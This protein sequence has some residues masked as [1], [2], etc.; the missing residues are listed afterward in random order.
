MESHRDGFHVKSQ[1]KGKGE[2]LEIL[3]EPF[4]LQQCDFKVEIA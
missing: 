1:A 2:F 4:W 3:R